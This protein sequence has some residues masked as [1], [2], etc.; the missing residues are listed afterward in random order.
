MLAV[1]LPDLATSSPL[2]LALLTVGVNAI[3]GAL[4]AYTDT[5]RHWD[6]VGVTSFALLM[7]LG[8]GFLRDSIIG[9]VP[10][11]SLRCTWS[12]MTVVGAVVIV[13]LI[14]RWASRA[15][16]LL[17]FLNALALGLFAITGVARALDV[18]AAT[19]PQEM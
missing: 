11:E 8:G 3:V 16:P 18:G 10:A 17:D 4:R 12:L 2:W 1:E 5:T 13:L 7:G 6:I 15:Q 9:N 19:I 14:G